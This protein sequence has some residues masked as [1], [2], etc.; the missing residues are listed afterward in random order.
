MAITL[1]STSPIRAAI[2]V[3][4]SRDDAGDMLG[5]RRQEKDARALCDR[6]GWTVG[7][8]FCDDDVSAWSGVVR[9]GYRRMLEAIAARDVDAVVAYDLDRLHRIPRELEEFFEACDNVALVNLATVS[10]DVDL[11]TNDGRLV[12]RIMGAV[13]KKSSDDTSRRLRRKFDE[14]AEQGRPHGGRAFGYDADG[15]TVRPDEAA[16]LRQAAKDVLAGESLAGI[17]RRWNDL[18]VRTSQRA[19]PW[20]GTVVRFVLTNPRQAGL[21]VHR[22]EVV[23]PGAWPAIV[24]RATH[25]R[26]VATL[27][28]PG[29]RQAPPRRTPFTGLVRCGLCGEKM[30]RD[31]VGSLPTYRCH[32]VV[33]R[34]G[35]GRMSISA[36]PLER[37]VVEAV[38][39]RLDTP[40]LVEHLADADA[41]AGNQDDEL[42]Q[43][44][45]RLGELAELWAAGD[46]TKGEWMTARKG[47]ERRLDAA[48]RA[49]VRSGKSAVLA[50]YSKPGALR[51]A[52]PDLSSDRQRAVLAAIID[53][54][55]VL[56]ATRRGPRFDGARID[57][58]WRA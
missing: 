54:I 49:V 3:R 36:V 5:V 35:C 42:A 38:L 56:P 21:R 41:P 11:G 52:W 12:A 48:R 13:A 9:P 4:I 31:A 44:E 18:G 57:L 29:R 30:T 51:A 34:I 37:I 8:V 47:I 24:D 28:G 32:K 22:G 39:L 25:E 55:N 43:L 27:A 15:V 26:L 2:Y 14:M 1:Q 45:G 40:A 19:R 58:V 17:A 23:G 16:L 46:L 6:K 50:D 7:E 10:G 33:G 53:R 20:T